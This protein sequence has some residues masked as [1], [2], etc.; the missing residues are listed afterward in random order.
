[1][2]MGM[3]MG[4]GESAIGRAG[5]AVNGHRCPAEDYIAIRNVIGLTALLGNEDA[6][7]D[8]RRDA[9]RG[10]PGVTP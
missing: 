5:Q 8:Y 10:K 1:M 4:M 2:G 3:G 6:P 9:A 7:E